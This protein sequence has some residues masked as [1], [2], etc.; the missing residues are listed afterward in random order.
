MERIVVVSS[1][2]AEVGYD[3]A[4]EILEVAFVSGGVY[5]YFDV[6]DAVYVGL[7]SAPSVGRYFDAYVKKAGYRYR[8]LTAG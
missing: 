1:N 5:Q 2:V 3:S 6:P 4:T 8:R 7:I